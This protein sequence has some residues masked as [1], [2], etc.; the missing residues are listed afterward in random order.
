MQSKAAQASDPSRLL[1]S[2]KVCGGFLEMSGSSGFPLR[3]GI[4]VDNLEDF[5]KLGQEFKDSSCDLLPEADDSFAGAPEMPAPLWAECH[6]G[7]CPHALRG[8][9]HKAYSTLIALVSET[10]MRQAPRPSC[11]TEEPLHLQFIAP[12][13]RVKRYAAV[14]YNFRKNQSMQFW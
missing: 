6:P 10:I 9:Q 13:A 12:I 7:T 11:P 5:Q 14:A 4:V 8:R 1:E 2:E 3:R